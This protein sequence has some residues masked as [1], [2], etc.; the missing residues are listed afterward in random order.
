LSAPSRTAS[1]VGFLWRLVRVPFWLGLGFAIGFLPLYVR[2]LDRQLR[3]RFDDFSWDLPS[4]VYARPLELKVGLPMSAETVL[5]ELD[6]ARYAAD[7]AAKIPG[8]Y[9][10]VAPAQ[11]GRFIIARRAFVDADGRQAPR[12]IALTLS[13]NAIST[14]A[15]ADSGATLDHARLDPARIATL[16]GAEQEERRVVKLEQLPPLLVAGL[17]AV[18]D[19]E[20]K[21]HHGI[22]V[23]SIARALL[24]NLLAGHMVQG[25]STLTQQLV[26]NLFLDNG[27]NLTRKFNEAIIALL[28]EARY[29]KHRILETYCNEVFLG[30]Q[31]G[32]AVH[33]FAAGA[34]FYFGR[35]AN[36][37]KPGEIALLVG[38]V[39]GPSLYDPRRHPDY[40]T[41]RRNIVLGMFYETGLIDAATLTATR[42]APLGV[43]DTPGLPRNRTP[44][45]LDLVRTQL[46]NDYPD[47]EL[48][49]AG[50]VIYTTLAPSTQALAEQALT[51]TLDGLGKK[52][53]ELQAAMIVTGA[54]DGEVQALIGARDADD[55]GFNRALDA[56][57]PIGSLVKPFVNLIAL[58]QPQKY[59]LASLLDDSTV[60]MV[61]P[62]GAHWTPQNDDHE[63]HG[64]VL[65]VDAL[66]HSYNLATVHLGLELGVDK[67]RGLLSSFGL[68][69]DINP[70]PSLLLGAVDLSPYQVAQLYQY[71]AADGHALPLRALRGVVD[72]QGKPLARYGVKPGAG[73]YVQPARLVN[74][75][76][77]QVAQVGTAR[78]IA[79]QGLGALHAAGKTGTSDSQRDS[80]FAGFTGTHL[81]VAWVGRDDNKQTDLYG[82]TGGLA[83]W[84][85]LMRKL[86]SAPL[87]IP[88]DGLDQAYVNPQSG[89]QTDAQCSGARQLPFM[90]GFTPQ[91]TDHCVLQEIKS[92]FSGNNN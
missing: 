68:D 42:A 4:R 1:I 84:T 18:E 54:R 86:P 69:A 65:L 39:Q 73:N 13:A 24:T 8:T 20:F 85:A 51:K 72:A 34:E 59:S 5:L 16:Y 26:K 81:A 76:L 37:L 35:D 31:G 3:S 29:D 70:N 74:F 17:Q 56:R 21:R 40:A 48:Q 58:A 92:I 10:Q 80:W 47:A 61:Q 60:D 66:A 2:D 46:R 63:T 83:I 79:D 88:Q 50:L 52:Q 45:F 57:R 14:L 55:P 89:A 33:G 78:A 22:N 77:Q 23:I 7:P 87:V 49:R 9:A 36:D 43:P 75:A 64:R 38:M 27:R 91:D 30:Q 67:V 28:I 90:A 32:Q 41:T 71:F 12:R 19:R 53:A 82:R 15:D 6:A 44:A 62:N 25:G 11:S